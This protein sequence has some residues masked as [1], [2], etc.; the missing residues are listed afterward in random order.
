MKTLHRPLDE[1]GDSVWKALADGT[2]R[3]LLDVLRGGPK[4]TG[5]LCALFEMSRFGVMKHLTVLEAAGL[6]VVER[7]GRERWNHLN[8]VPIREVYRRWMMPFAAV[9]ADRLLKLK[10]VAERA[11]DAVPAKKTTPKSKATPNSKT[12]TKK[13]TKNKKRKQTRRRRK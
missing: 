6:V 9:G 7:R 1:R 2:R 3:T 5:E 4:T 10:R 11:N 12:K 8:A 13:T